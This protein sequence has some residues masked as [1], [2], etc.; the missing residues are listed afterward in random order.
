MFEGTR[1]GISG[2]MELELVAGTL[3]LCDGGLLNW[4]AEGMFTS[5]D[6]TYGTLG[7][8]DASGDGIGDSAA[9]GR[10]TLNVPS[11]AAAVDLAQPEMQG[12]A[13]RFWLAEVDLSTGL[14]VGTP[15]K[16][17]EGMVDTVSMSLGKNQRDGWIDYMDAGERLFSV[18]EGHALT[19]RFHQTAWPGE[20]GF[21]F[22]TGVGIAVPWGVPDPGRATGLGGLVSDV[23]AFKFAQRN[24]GT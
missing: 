24:A 21:D 3:R 1:I 7:G 2:L 14:L 20:L 23:L 5:F 22:C 8:V 18:R 13:L 12:K 11:I 16:M 19:T 4:P 9:G 17:F 10:L 6:T 15:E